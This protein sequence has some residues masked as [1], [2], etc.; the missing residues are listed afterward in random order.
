MND[1][2]LTRFVTDLGYQVE[3]THDTNGMAYTLI[4]DVTIPAGSLTGQVCDIALARTATMPYTVASAV[5]VRPALV[6]MDMSGPLKT[7][8]SALG[9]NWQYWSRRYDRPPIP[10]GIWAHVLTVLSEV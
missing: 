4:R 9:S 10:R 3:V 5:H 1:D 2:D 6:P 8:A 7:Q